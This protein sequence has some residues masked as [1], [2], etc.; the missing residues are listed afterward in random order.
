M[1][2]RRSPPKLASLTNK[3][4][5]EQGI[6]H[7]PVLSERER[8]RIL[9]EWNDTFTMY[10]DACV[11]ELFE[12]QV[13]RD[14]GAVAVICKD[15]QLTY[16]ELN[17]RANQVAQ[18]LRKRGVG[19]ESLVGVCLRHSPE[20]VIALLGVWK[21]GGAYVPF[22]PA[23]PQDRL[24][25]MVNDTAAIL[26]LT[27]E[28]CRNLFPSAG[29]RAVSLDSVWPVIAQENI[30]NP[31]AVA[32]PSNLAY[33]MYTSG[34]TG[35][36]KGAMIMHSSLV[37]YLCWAIKTYVVEAGSSV[38]VHSSIAFDSTV[39]SLYPPLLSGGAIELLPE[40]I[41]AQSLVAALRQKKIEAR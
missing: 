20:M 25:F 32:T 29:D 37:N 5:H 3:N 30:S 24:S 38:P 13:A 7:A 26:L 19:P 31:T 33:V 11:H 41:G 23:Y 1:R 16:Q 22:D 40:D 9:Y 28:K 2:T 15:R 39:A 34:S 35:Q 8:H 10:P 17:Q 6:A 14:P 4:M 18:Y 21:A 27:D 36:P 12:Q